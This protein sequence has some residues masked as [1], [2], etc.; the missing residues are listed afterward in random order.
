MLLKSNGSKLVSRK[1]K[2]SVVYQFLRLLKAANKA[3]DIQKKKVSVVY[4]FL[5]LLKA[6]FLSP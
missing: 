5:R 1:K 4:Q 3:G 2:V 6:Y